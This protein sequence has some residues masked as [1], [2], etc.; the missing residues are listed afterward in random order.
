MLK[1]QGGRAAGT[2]APSDPEATPAATQ[3]CPSQPESFAEVVRGAFEGPKSTEEVARGVQEAD[4]V[5]FW[6]IWGRIRGVRSVWRIG[7]GESRSTVVEFGLFHLCE[8]L[9]LDFVPPRPPFGRSLALLGRFLDSTGRSWGAPVGP[10]G[11][12]WASSGA[13]LGASWG[14]LGRSGAPLGPPMALWALRGPFW[15]RFGV[16]NWLISD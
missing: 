3:G 9:G 8:R 12:F 13:A 6:P 5:R 1:G 10:K 14:T 11:A 16:E 2:C 7:K 4:L 15:D